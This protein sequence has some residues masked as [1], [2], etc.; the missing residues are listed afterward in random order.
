MSMNSMPMPSMSINRRK[1]LTL[2]SVVVLTLSACSEA[3]KFTTLPK[4]STVIALGDSLTYGYG[5]TTDTAYPKILAQKTGWKVLNEGISG[6]TSED[7]LN[8]LNGI[9]Q[10]NPDLVL[11]GV[12]GNDVLQRIQPTTTKANL[13][14][15]LTK[16][17][18]EHIPVVL[19]TEPHFSTSALFGKASDNP[20]YAELSE[21]HDVPLFTGKMGGWSEILSDESLKSDKIH[22][23]EAGYRQFADNLYAYLQEIGYVS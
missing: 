20:I 6:D 22:A 4:D 2:A 9:I 16:L 3:P 8:R 23:N 14:T 7:V 18:N 15:I 19:I 10:Q 11:L 13:D 17:K 21:T 1:F 12:G 5:A